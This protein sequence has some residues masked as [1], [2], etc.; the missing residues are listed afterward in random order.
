MNYSYA[1]KWSRSYKEAIKPLTE[2]K[3]RKRH[4]SGQLYSVLIGNATR[5]TSFVEIRG[6]YVGV[7]FNDE[8][9]E[10]ASSFT[11]Q[12]QPDGRLF[13]SRAVFRQFD[14]TKKSVFGHSLHFRPDGYVLSVE[15]DFRTNTVT[16][17]EKTMDVSLNWEPYPKFGDYEG[18]ARFDR[19][20]PPE[21]R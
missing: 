21:Q 1:E 2:A 11:F 20:A 3:A 4:E 5:P 19:D 12:R 10:Q 8:N 18:I 17:R 13:M 9:L 16:R 14:E 7:E 15:E 6:D